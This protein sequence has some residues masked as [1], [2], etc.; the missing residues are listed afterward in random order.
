[1]VLAYSHGVLVFVCVVRIWM[2]MFAIYMRPLD[3]AG[4]CIG[5]GVFTKWEKNGAT[6]ICDVFVFTAWCG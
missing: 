4:F 2:L 1:M 5:V 3:M 6:G